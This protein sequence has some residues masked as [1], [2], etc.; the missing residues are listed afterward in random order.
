[1]AEVLQGVRDPWG[2]EQH[3]PVRGPEGGRWCQRPPPD[4]LGR[5]T[6]VACDISYYKEIRGQERQ[7]KEL[8][9]ELARLG[10]T[11]EENRKNR[12]KIKAVK[13]EI[14]HISLGRMDKIGLRHK[15]ELVP[16]LS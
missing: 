16:Q 2:P 9:A 14:A 13:A 15:Q 1:M 8:T 3:G 6:F 4:Q 12:K 5:H 10:D 11:V 7:V